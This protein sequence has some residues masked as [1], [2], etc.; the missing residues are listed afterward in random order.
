MPTNTYNDTQYTR[1]A[2][3][4][5]FQIEPAYLAWYVAA[6]GEKMW[7]DNATG[8]L[9]SAAEEYCPPYTLTADLIAG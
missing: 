3:A 9:L 2:A 8:E 7:L 4:K 1:E 5:R 6:D